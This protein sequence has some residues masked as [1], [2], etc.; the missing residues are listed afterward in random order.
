MPA[1]KNNDFAKGNKGGG[2]I[3]Y[4]NEYQKIAYH[5]A[6]LGADKIFRNLNSVQQ[7]RKFI[8]EFKYSAWIE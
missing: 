3:A 6:L 2:T 8:T 7:Y 5:M 4:N 1:P